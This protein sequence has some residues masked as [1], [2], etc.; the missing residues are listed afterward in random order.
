M[1]L[2]RDR[3]QVVDWRKARRSV[4]TGECVE[5]APIVGNIVVR[6][7]MNPDGPVLQYSTASWRSFL[8]AAKRGNFDSL[9]S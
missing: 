1:S 7:S 8:I 5:V 6:D 4:A 3:L 9:R 2:N